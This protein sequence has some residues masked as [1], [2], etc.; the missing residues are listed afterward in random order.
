MLVADLGIYILFARF[1]PQGR[2]PKTESPQP[3]HVPSAPSATSPSPNPVTLPS[4]P[5]AATTKLSDG[6]TIVNASP[7]YLCGFFKN[8][9]HIQAQKLVAPFIG[10]WIKITGRV[11][12]IVDHSPHFLS[13][14]LTEYLQLK[15]TVFIYFE[16]VWRHKLEQ[17]KPGDQMTLIGRIDMVQEMSMDLKKCELLDE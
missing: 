16:S 8:H 7:E 6:R 12:N 5:G 15:L 4:M 10:E 14:R 11:E 13:V 3:V 2:I 9:M 1:D 17:F